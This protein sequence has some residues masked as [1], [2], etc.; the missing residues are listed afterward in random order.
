MPIEIKELHIKAVVNDESQ[1]NTPARGNDSSSNMRMDAIIEK[2][3][4][5][6]LE[7]LKEKKER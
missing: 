1:Q 5:Q 7:I 2:C 6:V 3:V 4:E